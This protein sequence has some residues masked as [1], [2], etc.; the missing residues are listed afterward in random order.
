MS[1]RRTRQKYHL[2]PANQPPALINPPPTNRTQPHPSTQPRQVVRYKRD[3]GVDLTAT[4]YLPPGHDPAKDGP[5]P[6]I[7]WA[8]PREFKSK[9][10]FLDWVVVD[11][12]GLTVSNGWLRV[13]RPRVDAVDP[14]APAY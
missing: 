2:H 10:G 13:V 7:L 12:V 4:L 9:V 8:Y 1:N 14:A 3:D 5:L 6:T 11:W